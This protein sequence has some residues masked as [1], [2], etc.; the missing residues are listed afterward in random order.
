MVGDSHDR[1]IHLSC[2]YFTIEKVINFAGLG[3][4]EVIIS[5]NAA[6]FTSEEFEQFSEDQT[7]EDT[8]VSPL[9]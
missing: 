6:N 8:T 4:P 7:C 9:F 1:I 5:D 3:L 2:H